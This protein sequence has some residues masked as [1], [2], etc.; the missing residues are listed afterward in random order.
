MGVRLL[1]E[2]HMPT[3]RD[4][5]PLIDDALQM[6]NPGS[7]VGASTCINGD[8]DDS[9]IAT[10]SLLKVA[11]TI[12]EEIL[13]FVTEPNILICKESMLTLCNQLRSAISR[14]LIHKP[15]KGSI[16]VIQQNVTLNRFSNRRS[17]P[18]TIEADEDI[19]YAPINKNKHTGR[20]PKGMQGSKKRVRLSKLVK[21]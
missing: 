18:C 16:R 8:K 21:V 5:L 3:L 7:S 19:G 20:L 17:S 13:D 4:S 2:Q 15:K 11:L 9:I 10:I 12:F 14:S 1:I 6:R